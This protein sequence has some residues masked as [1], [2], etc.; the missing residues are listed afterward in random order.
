MNKIFSDSSEHELC[1]AC[2]K[3][4]VA[5]IYYANIS[6]TSGTAYL[7]RHQMRCH[8]YVGSEQCSYYDT[9]GQTEG[10]QSDSHTQHRHV[11]C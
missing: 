9:V 4:Q 11:P 2:L 5:Y 10:R 3:L 7:E 1:P 6:P 8:S